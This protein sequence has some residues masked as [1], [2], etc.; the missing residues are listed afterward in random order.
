YNPEPPGRWTVTRPENYYEQSRTGLGYFYKPDGVILELH[1]HNTMPAY[2]S[3]RDNRDE[4][5]GRL[6]GVIGHLERS[7]PELAL[8][9]GMFGHWL[10]NVPGRAIFDDVTPFI[11]VELGGEA[12]AE[13]GWVSFD[14]AAPDNAGNFLTNLFRRRRQEE[15]R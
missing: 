13:A 12:E 14:E 9:L 4:L 15:I 2:F 6:Y 11:E 1:S 3:P 8:R 5:G 10:Y 7:N